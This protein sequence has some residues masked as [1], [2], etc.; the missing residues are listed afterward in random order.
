MLF[1][2]VDYERR[3]SEN[4]SLRSENDQFKVQAAQLGEK[5][6]FWMACPTS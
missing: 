2:L 3:V 1:M 4:D 5:I 6:D